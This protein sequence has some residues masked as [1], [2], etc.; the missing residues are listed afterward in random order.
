MGDVV[1][2][3]DEELRFEADPVPDE[4]SVE[5]RAESPVPSAVLRPSAEP[6][7]MAGRSTVRLLATLEIINEGVLKGTRFRVERP[8][9]HVGRAPHNDVRLADSTV[10]GLHATL[11]RRSSGWVVLDHGSTNGTYV[12]GERISG[13]RQLSNATELR[14]GNIKMVFRSIAGG[15]D[16][17]A[18]STRAV[19][20]VS[21]QQS[22]KRR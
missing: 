8:V 3:G 17:D 22:R 20:G 12:D 16:V 10:S 13:E 14:F 11:T 21:L 1:R 7:T 19:V 9:A 6:P 2:V 5:P 15:T 18:T 4:P